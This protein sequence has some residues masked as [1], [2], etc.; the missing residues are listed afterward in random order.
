MMFLYIFPSL[1]ISL[2]E[3][4][5]KEKKSSVLNS[6]CNK[7]GK[8]DL[9][10]LCLRTACEMEV[11]MLNRD[12]RTKVSF[13]RSYIT[14]RKTDG[15]AALVIKQQLKGRINFVSDQSLLCSVLQLD[16]KKGNNKAT[17]RY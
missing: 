3:A 12:K 13:Q 8:K 17:T 10:L 14:A 16:S 5:F 9:L 6:F 2:S 11:F 1:P 7:T 15:G 4:F